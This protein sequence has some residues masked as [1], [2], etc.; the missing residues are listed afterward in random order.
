MEVEKLNK[1]YVHYL[2]QGESKSIP[3]SLRWNS[4][5]FTKSRSRYD[6]IGESWRDLNLENITSFYGAT[7]KRFD[8]TNNLTMLAFNVL[9]IIF[10]NYSMHQIIH[11]RKIFSNKIYSVNVKIFYFN[12]TNI[13]VWIQINVDKL[14]ELAIW[15][16]VHFIHNID[17]PYCA[18]TNRTDIRNFRFRNL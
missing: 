11:T 12:K 13:L 5:F 7:G 6:F 10:I 1:I 16:P 17:I 9:T 14:L 3:N 8:G 2:R 18:R 4:T 15:K